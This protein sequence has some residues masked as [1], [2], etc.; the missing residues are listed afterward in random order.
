MFTRSSFAKAAWLLPAGLL[1]PLATSYSADVS[2]SNVGTGAFNL[3]TNWNPATVPT[4]L[5]NAII[6]NGG[7]AQLLLGE[8]AS[9]AQ[10]RVIS[11][12]LSLDDAT[13]ATELVSTGWQTTGDLQVGATGQTGALTLSGTSTITT[14]RVRIGGYNNGSESS[15]AIGSLTMT[16]SSSLTTANGYDFWLGNGAGS[17]GTLTMSGS[18]IINVMNTG[19]SARAGGTAIV[20]QSGT[21]QFITAGGYVFGEGGSTTWTATEDSVLQIGG[22]I[23]IGDGNNGNSTMNVQDSAI[24]S[25]GGE[26][27]VG[28]GNGGTGVY[29]Q[30]GGT[31][32]SNSWVA[33]GRGGAKG[34]FNISGGSFTKNGTGAWTGGGGMSGNNWVTNGS[35]SNVATINQ[36]GGTI[37]NTGSAM[38]LS[39]ASGNVTSWSASAGTGNFG[40]FHV[41]FRGDATVTISGSANYGTTTVH[42]GTNGSTN[43]V[44]NL[45][46]G[47]FAAN[48][49]TEGDG[50][51][52]L[53]FDGG[54]LKARVSSVDLIAGFE[55]GDVNLG[56]G[57][58]TVDTDG[59][60]VSISSPI[61]GAGGLTK[62]GAGQ[63][64]LSGVNTYSGST[65]ISGGTLALGGSERL[66][67]SSALNLNSGTLDL[68]GF[69]ETLSSLSLGNTSTINFGSSMGANVLAFADSSA[70][71]W[72]GTLTLSNFQ[73]GIDTLN[74][75]PNGLTPS[76]LNAISLPGYQAT[77]LNGSGDVIFTAVPE[78]SSVSLMIGA[79]LVIG[80]SVIVRRKRRIA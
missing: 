47:T 73:V 76:Q 27:W 53:T 31:V 44:L 13:L 6:S 37:N 15:N 67:N 39:E 4:N 25:S 36:T 9:V 79:A 77:G 26:F 56:A 21:S 7:T 63:L 34:T 41:G 8:A 65:T 80:G 12:S 74:F 1:L 29:N 45:Q 55:S 23:N 50:N 17:V 10:M 61:S 49:I 22:T 72:L 40:D 3:N 43:G 32:S 69:S 60:T 62:A 18:S 30:T 71:A 11:G 2:W 58:G 20:T 54:T 70:I 78:P 48:S 46:G 64:T 28:N 57:G 42:L 75:S 68:G 38:I 5:D 52:T 35:A 24:V 59:N 51:G 33:V 19:T 16:G 66:S 14:G